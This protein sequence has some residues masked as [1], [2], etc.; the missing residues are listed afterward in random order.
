MVFPQQKGVLCMYLGVGAGNLR[1]SSQ[2]RSFH[3]LTNSS[4]PWPEGRVL[5]VPFCAQN[6]GLYSH[7]LEESAFSLSS[8]G[9]TSLCCKVGDPFAHCAGRGDLCGFLHCLLSAHHATPHGGKK[10]VL[11]PLML[12]CHPPTPL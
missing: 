2:W 11:G 9:F 6:M 10:G 5:A 8:G 4:E 3:L 12:T 1:S 7:R